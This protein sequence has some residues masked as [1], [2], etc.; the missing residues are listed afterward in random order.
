MGTQPALR[1]LP[2]AKRRQKAPTCSTSSQPPSPTPL[3]HSDRLRHTQNSQNK[4][5]VDYLGINLLTVILAVVIISALLTMCKAQHIIS[6]QSYTA[7]SHCQLL[8][9]K[10]WTPFIM[11]PEITFK[12][13]FQVYAVAI[14]KSL[15]TVT[16][17]HRLLFSTIGVSEEEGVNAGIV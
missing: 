8:Y 7:Y 9:K 6:L 15:E 13:G 10:F 12:V 4:E 1:Q 14:M 3:T 11:I 5:T 17:I 16:V 2:G